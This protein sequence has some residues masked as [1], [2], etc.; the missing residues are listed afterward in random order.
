MW[1]SAPYIYIANSVGYRIP[2]NQGKLKPLLETL[3]W[4]V[5]GLV[6]EF[7]FMSE[8]YLMSGVSF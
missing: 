5:N 4:K 7:F 8:V 6:C 1:A 2:G 3:S